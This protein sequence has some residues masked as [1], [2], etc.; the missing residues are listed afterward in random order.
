MMINVTLFRKDD[1]TD[2]TQRL[3]LM[4]PCYREMM[5]ETGDSLSSTL[6]GLR[7]SYYDYN[8]SKAPEH[9]EI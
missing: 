6:A 4:C 7:E 3:L 8:M 2:V 5:G 1:I 9:G